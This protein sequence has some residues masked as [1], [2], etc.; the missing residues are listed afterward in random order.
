MYAERVALVAEAAHVVPPIGAQGLNMSLGDLRVLLDLAE[1]TPARLGDL[2][3]L[4]TYH[5]HRHA[6]VMARVAGI[7]VLNRA[8]MVRAQ[9]LR[10]ARAMALDTIYSL[11]PVR[12]SLMQLG[13]GARG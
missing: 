2:A 3:M 10:D 4:E 1:Q 7:D 6:E 5:R 12:K 11:P 8:S 13:L 9:P